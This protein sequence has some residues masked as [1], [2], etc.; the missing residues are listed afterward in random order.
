M[1]LVAKLDA[2]L[3]MTRPAWRWLGQ[4]ALVVLGTHLAADRM[5]DDLARLLAEVPVPWPDP[6]TPILVGAWVAVAMELL[7][8]VWAVLAL[9]R[10]LGPPI[11]ERA[12][13]T[14]TTRA[15]AALRT[16]AGRLSLHNLIGPL[17]WLPVGLAG[18]WVIA[19]AI[20]DAL[21]AGEIARWVGYAVGALAAWRLVAPGAVRLVLY[22][23]VP[24]RRIEGWPFA[25]AL[26]A[27]GA[28]AAWYGLP[29]WGLSALWGAG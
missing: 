24:R 11:T 3:A 9:A 26:L 17:F 13:G 27:V 7:V 19:M 10:T 1:N 25:P 4:V 14:R 29:I 2:S 18:C 23:P 28:Y 8:T 12:L 16:W 21:P 15:R 22:A 20:E 5:D 6:Q